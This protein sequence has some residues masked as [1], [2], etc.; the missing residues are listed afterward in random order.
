MLSNKIFDTHCHLL[1]SRFSGEMET[2][3][4]G[5]Y[6]REVQGFTE[7]GFDLPSSEAGVRLAEHYAS[8]KKEAIAYRDAGKLSE[9]DWQRMPE[10]YAAVGIHPDH[11]D[12]LTPEV[13][14]ALRDLS[15]SLRV[16]AIGEIGLDYHYTREG[17]R[18]TAEKLGKEPDPEALLA[19]D[20]EPEI[21]KR[22]FREMLRL[23]REVKLPIN[24]HSRDAAKDTYDILVE[25]RGFEQGG[26]VHCFGYSYEMAEQFAKL[27]MMIGIGGVV[28][29]K[30]ARK[31]IEVAEKL[32]LESIVLE[33]DSPYM[34]PTPYRGTRNDP[35]NLP[36]IA[37][38]IA[39]LKGMH[40]EDVVRITTENAARVY[41]IA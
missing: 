41:R 12:T 37:A 28:T 22:T 39:E 35:G 21:Q 4:G 2:I 17:I 32:P 24:I 18:K 7:I 25:E 23:A 11:S 8:L 3:I 13:Y 9:E 38:K 40:P 33:T 1:D 34:A 14:D 16:V 20:P 36:Y 26:I 6:D 31:L 29:F 30:N 10:V 19:A 5:L 27:G 15:K